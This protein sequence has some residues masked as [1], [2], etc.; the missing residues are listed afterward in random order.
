MIILFPSLM[1]WLALDG[2]MHPQPTV[3]SPQLHMV[4]KWCSA[5]TGGIGHWL[6]LRCCPRTVRIRTRPPPQQA[7]HLFGIV[8]PFQRNLMA[9]HLENSLILIGAGTMQTMRVIF[10]LYFKILNANIHPNAWISM[11]VVYV[12]LYVR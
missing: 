3:H 9:M 12:V 8:L 2:L 11:N 4:M 5:E 1:K 6:V 10:R 7:E